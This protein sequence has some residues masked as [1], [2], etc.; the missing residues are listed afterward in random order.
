[1]SFKFGMQTEAPAEFFPGGG[2]IQRC[3]FVFS[4]KLTTCHWWQS[5]PE[6]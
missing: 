1:M 6:V 4:K 3:T 2:Q 5:K